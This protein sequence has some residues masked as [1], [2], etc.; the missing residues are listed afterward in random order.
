MLQL[1]KLSERGIAMKI[2][3]YLLKSNNIERDSFV[4][5]MA[6]SMLMA[7][8]SVILLMIL[9]RTV[10]LVDAGIFT[11]AY[12]NANLFLNIGKYGMRNF[13]VSDIKRQ[14]SFQEYLNSRWITVVIMILISIVYTVYAAL[15]NHYTVEKMM[16]IIWMCL[17]KVPDAIEDIYY[18][19]YQKK[20]RLDV[21][22]KILTWRMIL[23]LLLFSVIVILSGNLLLS[24][25]ISTIFT[26]GI[27]ILFIKWTKSQF[28]EEYKF[29]WKQ[30][31]SILRQCF[32]LAVGGFLSFYIGNAPKYAIDSLLTDEL[33]AC[34]GFIA[35]PVFVIGLLNNFVFSPLLYK[36]S[37][38]WNQKKIKSFLKQ[39]GIQVG[40]VFLIT[41]TCIIGAYL[42]GIP[43]LS[44]L[45]N[46]DLTNYKTELLVLLAGGGFLGLSGLLCAVITI[47]RRQK[48]LLG[49]YVI[50]ALLALILSK[51]I[52]AQYE[53]LG[54]AVLYMLLMGFLCMCF[55]G[56][57][58][59]GVWKKS[60]SK[61][62]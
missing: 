52:V 17:F 30:V 38:L 57:F 32:P 20:G 34:Y 51:P 12:A 15:V 2:Q 59:W 21:G 16:I 45:Y 28:E 53:M 43:V 40:I 1:I 44:I 47:I 6:G 54:A 36:I 49:G 22:A 58:A 60:K 5:N 61:D 46:T 19:D 37:L 35:M 33:Q 4:W 23:T 39:T 42:I 24:L 10:G 56:I 29:S 62:V 13:Q 18:G 3:K 11:I 8:Q 41:I 9:T 48:E 50:V 14:F 7:F 31:Q 27:M 26:T 55:G 25:I